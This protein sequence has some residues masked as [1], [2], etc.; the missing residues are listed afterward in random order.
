MAIE[1]VVNPVV[2]LIP[3]RAITVEIPHV[4]IAVSVA[5]MHISPAVPLPFEYSQG[6]TEFEIINFLVRCTKYLHFLLKRLHAPPY[7]MP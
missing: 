6:C 5:K 3:L 7:F 4:A 2:V 1:P